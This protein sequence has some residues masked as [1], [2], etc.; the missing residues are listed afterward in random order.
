MEAVARKEAQKLVDSDV[1]DID[2]QLN[3]IIT[4]I[5]ILWLSYLSFFYLFS[6]FVKDAELYIT[7]PSIE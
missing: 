3:D 6:F 7:H 2:C 4:E 1:Q 5:F